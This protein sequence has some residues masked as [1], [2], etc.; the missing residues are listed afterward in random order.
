VCAQARE[1]LERSAL[2]VAELKAK[3]APAWPDRD[4]EALHYTV[5][6]YLPL[7]QVPPAGTWGAGRPPAYALGDRWLDAPL[8][9]DGDPRELVRRYLAAF[10]PATVKDVQAWAGMTRLKGAVQALRDELATFTG[11][12]GEEL[13]DLPDAPRPAADAP[14]PV[15]FLPEYDN[16]LL[17]HA[18]R[19]R[20]IADEHRP[21]VFLSAGRVRSTFLVE[22]RVAGAWKAERAKDAAALTL[23]PFAPLSMRDRAAL[24]DEAERLLAFVAPEAAR[25][26]VRVAA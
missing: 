25:R 19:T 13:V 9:D 17:A 24:T 4:P 1:E 22:G 26:A 15:R 2:T 10:G 7:V 3:L 8:H 14:A 5:R 6:A 23:E 20:V 16:V 12:H 18:D 11:E 21:R